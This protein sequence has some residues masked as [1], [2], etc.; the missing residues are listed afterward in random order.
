MHLKAPT[1]EEWADW[2]THPVTEWARDNLAAVL[3]RQSAAATSAYWAGKAWP[4]ADRQSLV[5]LQAWHEDFFTAT[6][7]DMMAVTEADD[8]QQRNSPG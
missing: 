4:E 8:E 2:L 7:E 6:L 5:R 3:D 1:P